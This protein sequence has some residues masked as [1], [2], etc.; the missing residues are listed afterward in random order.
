[1]SLP[2]A[3]P[4]PA[5]IPPILEIGLAILFGLLAA[6]PMQ[7]VARLYETK[8]SLPIAAISGAVIGGL[9]YTLAGSGTAGIST[10]VIS[11]L[12]LLASL[13][14]L[15]VLRLPNPLVILIALI[16][17][18]MSVLGVGPTLPDALSGALVGLVLMGLTGGLYQLLRRR[19]GLGMG[20]VKIA[21]ALGLL[22]GAQGMLLVLLAA[23]LLQ[24]LIGL[25][26]LFFGS[27]KIRQ[28]QPFGPA[29]ALAA[30]LMMLFST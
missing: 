21:G 29:L 6:L 23:S 3:L 30:W 5:A 16:G 19:S 20:D 28:E 13:I 9:S 27:G 8:L 26:T 17:L 14:D 12:L 18:G 2:F 22:V 11:L 7:Q 15:A 10:L 25:L 1:M 4:D 24:A